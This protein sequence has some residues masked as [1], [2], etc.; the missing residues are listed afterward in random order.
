[1]LAQLQAAAD[2]LVQNAPV[3]T[4]GG[5][6]GATVFYGLH[7]S[8]LGVIVS[9]LA[10]IC[11]VGLQFY[12]AFR[13]IRQRKEIASELVKSTANIAAK[14]ETKHDDEASK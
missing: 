14:L 8:E 6:A 9:A 4:Y 5:T 1:M 12:L 3:M 2:K 7:I 10:S 11:G 13:T